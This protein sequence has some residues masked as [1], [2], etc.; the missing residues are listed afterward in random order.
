MIPLRV[1]KP[2][3]LVDNMNTP[4]D[5]NEA[6]AIYIGYGLNS[7][8]KEDESRLI[9]KYGEK[10]GNDLHARVRGILKELG[11]IQP[12]WNNDSLITAAEKASR[13]VASTHPELDETAIKAM[14]WIF[15][16]WWK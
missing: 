6:I 3:F 14:Q 11:E 13:F 2:L 12:D 1:P 8:P 16:W 9:K 7:F 15:T 10:N 5:I 4:L